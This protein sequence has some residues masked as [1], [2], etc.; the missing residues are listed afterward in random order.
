MKRIFYT[1]T[2]AFAVA[3][4]LCAP[5]WA[6][7]AQNAC[8]M[9]AQTGEV[10][11]AQNETG[12]ALIASTTKIM[13]GLLIC[14]QCNLNAVIE[15]PED[16]V[17]IEGSSVYLKARER[18]RIEDLLYAM[19]LQSGNDAAMCL[20]IAHSGSQEAFVARMNE[21]AQELGLCGTH[22]ANPHGLDDAGNYSTAYDLAVLA[23]AAMENETFAKVVSTKQYRFGNRTVTNHNKLLWRL[24]GAQGVKTGYTKAAGR[25]LVSSA[26]RF[27]R[28]LI[29]VTISDPDD[30]NDHCTLLENGFSRYEVGLLCKEGDIFGAV[31]SENGTDLVP[32]CAS[33]DVSALLLPTEQ[34]NRI[35]VQIEPTGK[36]YVLFYVQDA[37][38]ASCPLR[39]IGEID[40]GTHTENHSEQGLDLTK[41]CGEPD[42]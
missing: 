16:A 25:I 41:R 24:E 9:D 27:G 26:M 15:V 40:G 32:L 1:V 19:M 22:F 13:T 37:I 2:A 5:V 28:R 21:R 3:V 12:K 39:K 31:L 7:S 29:C 11:F 33:Q 23:C 42:S 18:L 20:A 34:I 30:W 10:L 38:A 35:Q 6:I 8:V 14:E 4:M 17:G 36:S